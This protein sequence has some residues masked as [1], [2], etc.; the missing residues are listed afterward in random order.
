MS[1][2]SGQSS[3]ALG[4]SAYATQGGSV[5][6]S[7]AWNGGAYVTETYSSQPGQLVLRS[8][9]GTILYTDAASTSGVQL[10]PGSGS[11]DVLS[12]RNRKDNFRGVDGESL[13][14]QLRAIPVSSWNYKSQDASISHIGP[15]AQD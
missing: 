3:L 4:S 9:G 10:L 8:T 5:V 2:A 1:E 13:L 11:W 15:I 14:L 6:I 12:D 7:A